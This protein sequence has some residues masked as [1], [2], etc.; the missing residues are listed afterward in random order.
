MVCMD[1]NYDGKIGLPEHV[2]LDRSREDRGA[3]ADSDIDCKSVDDGLTRARE[4]AVAGRL[5]PRSSGNASQS[6][7]GHPGQ[8]GE[9][10]SSGTARDIGCLRNPGSAALRCPVNNGHSRLRQPAGI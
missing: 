10:V 2:L 4:R 5:L 8:R 6:G 9:S 1:G 3:G 7:E